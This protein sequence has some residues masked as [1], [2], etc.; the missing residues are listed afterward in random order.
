MNILIVEDEVMAARRLER[1]TRAHLGKRVTNIR[2]ANGLRSATEALDADA[3]DLIMLDLNLAG[4]DGF[5]LIRRELGEARIIVVSAFPDRAI[6]AFGYAV[7][8][9]VPKPV[10]QERLA[11][12]LDRAVATQSSTGPKRL[13]VRNPGRA[14]F[15]DLDNIVRISGADD[16]CEVEL[17]SGRT[18]L[19]D[20][21]LAELETAL[22]EHFMRVHRS[23]IANLKHVTA[24][25]NEGSQHVL[26]QSDALRTPVGR[27]RV[28]DTKAL[29]AKIAEGLPK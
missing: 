27:R 25:E 9:F 12:A 1:L 3:F 26:V 23:F 28:K 20:Q 22:P 10:N 4:D 8:D 24:L 21:R 6:E 14:D 17:I 2:H 15:V 11:N 13:I 18:L 7:L 5:E 16:Y 19:H 29:L